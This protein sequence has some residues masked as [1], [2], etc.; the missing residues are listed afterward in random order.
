LRAVS[1]K[2][3]TRPDLD[4]TM[5]LGEFF[6]GRGLGPLAIEVLQRAVASAP[7]SVSA[8]LALGRA[9]EATGDLDLA[10]ASYRQARTLEGDGGDAERHMRWA[11]E[12]VAARR[13]SVTMTDERLANL[14]GR[15][16]DRTVTL[17]DGRLWY[18]GGPTPASWLTP[19]SDALFE[20]EI[21]PGTRLRFIGAE[22]DRP[23][24]LVGIYRD[25]TMDIWP[26]SP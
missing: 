15:Y 23:A 24:E 6:A 9:F 20:L 14:A 7:E 1:A 16:Q 4:E 18:E 11:E 19:M 2:P 10:M 22:G 3:A 25:G 8:N 5:E 21:D 12:R 17:N 13:D 26:R